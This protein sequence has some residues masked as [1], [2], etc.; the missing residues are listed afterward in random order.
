MPSNID[1]V[2]LNALLDDAI[3]QLAKARECAENSHKCHTDNVSLLESVI[4]KLKHI[5]ERRSSNV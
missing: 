2:D 5:K 1:S 4:L 3:S